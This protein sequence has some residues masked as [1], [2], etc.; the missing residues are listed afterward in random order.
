MSI[1]KHFIQNCS[2]R[3]KI[4]HI[5][6]ARCAKHRT[7]VTRSKKCTEA[8]ISTQHVKIKS[9]KLLAFNS[10][11]SIIWT[12]L[13]HLKLLEACIVSVSMMV[14]KRKRWRFWH[15][16]FRI[17]MKLEVR[18]IASAQV[19][20]GEATVFDIRRLTKSKSIRLIAKL[21]WKIKCKS[22][23]GSCRTPSRLLK[24]HRA[25]GIS[26]SANN[27]HKRDQGS[28]RVPTMS[29]NNKLLLKWASS[30]HPIS[31]Q[32]KKSH[33]RLQVSQEVTLRAIK[34]KTS[35]N[36]VTQQ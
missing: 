28:S 16:K 17:L 31:R 25:R 35:S 2:L 23:K 20:E 9:V 18:Q 30:P 15:V 1:C 27:I 34:A 14:M 29:T 19:C 3:L 11:T 24:T 6:R 10:L 4:K 5:S 13:E 7:A 8:S 36:L 33:G 32:F 12:Q 26:H 22:S 21:V